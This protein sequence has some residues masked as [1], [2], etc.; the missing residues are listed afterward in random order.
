[1]VKKIVETLI[2]GYRDFLSP[3]L[4]RNCRFYPSCS[5]Y[6]LAA[7]EKYGT[8]KGVLKAIVRIFK[9]HPLRGGGVDLP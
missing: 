4:G 3:S 5:S 7:I 2:K 9:C 6:A 8:F 1:M